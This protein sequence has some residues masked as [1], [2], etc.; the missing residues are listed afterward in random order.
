M[1]FK[2][3]NIDNNRAVNENDCANAMQPHT[4]EQWVRTIKYKNTT[5]APGLSGLLYAEIKCSDEGVQWLLGKLCNITTITGITPTCWH[6]GCY[7]M[8]PKK[9]NDP[10]LTKQRPLTLQEATR[11]ITVGIQ[12]R[13]MVSTWNKLG[14]IDSDQCAYLS[15]GSTVEPAVVNQTTG[16]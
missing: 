9:S 15:G 10:R 7:Y 4:K 1:K 2:H 14:L 5:S 8:I 11:K 16:S 6:H 13:R 3:T 12:R